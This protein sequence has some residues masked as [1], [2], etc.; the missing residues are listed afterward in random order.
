MKA[1]L[2]VDYINEI[3]H[4]EGKLSGKGY[5]DYIDSHNT[6]EYLNKLISEFRAEEELVIFVK[7]A[8]KEDYSDQPENSPLFGKAKEFGA[9]Q[10]GTWATEFH[11]QLN[12]QED[13]MV[14]TK[15]RV[16]AFHDTGLLQ[17]LRDS[18]I[19][20][21]HIAGV[22]TDLAVESVARTAHDNHFSVVIESQACAAAN[23]ADHDNS[24]RTLS[25]IAV[26]K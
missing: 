12:F 18:N 10:S 14:I 23:E 17:I 13:D 8:F 26:I 6:F 5:S 1:L 4:P 22:S 24:L 2:V 21:L 19:D 9:L 15:N 16:D 7:V 3:T 25:K 11:K 20:E